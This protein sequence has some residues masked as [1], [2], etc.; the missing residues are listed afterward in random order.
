ML[1]GIYPNVVRSSYLWTDVGPET[2]TLSGLDTAAT[3]N[4]EFF[5]SRDKSGDRTAEYSAGGQSAQL[6]AEFNSSNTVRLD[7]LRSN[8]DGT[9]PVTISKGSSIVAYLNA[10]VIEEVMLLPPSNFTAASASGQI[11]LT[12]TDN[13]SN[14]TGFEIERSLDPMTGFTAIGSVGSDITSFT[15][16]DAMPLTTYYYRVKA[17]NGPASSDYSDVITVE[18]PPISYTF[19]AIA[20]GNWSDPTIWSLTDG[21]TTDSQVPT[22]FDHVEIGAYQIEVTAPVDCR[23][24]K[25]TA[26]SS[27]LLLISGNQAK[28]TV[29]GEVVILNQAAVDNKILQVVNGGTLEC[30]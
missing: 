9:L 20:D 6:Q 18:N 26:G 25:I 12:W 1:T 15:D 24:V 14:E 27:T 29:D 22:Q 5:G 23:G 16:N 3:Y 7:S 28:L 4:L 19:Y 17:V 10:M 30:K 11:T 2:I 21:G 8:A 13:S